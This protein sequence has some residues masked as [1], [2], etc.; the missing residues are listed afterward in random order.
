MN[1]P[2]TRLYPEPHATRN[3][4]GRYLDD[5]LAPEDHDGPFVY[6]NFVTSLDGRIAI[7]EGAD[8]GQAVPRGIANARD[9]RLFQE[10]AG[11]ADILVTSGRYLRDLRAGT[12]QDVLPVSTKAAFADIHDW[13]HHHGMSPQP[14]VLVLSA[15]LDFDPPH[16]LIEQDRRVIILTTPDACPDRRAHHEAAGADV[17]LCRS[18]AGA[19]TG[20]DAYAALARRGYRRVYSVTGPD[21]LGTLASAGV[22]HALFLTTVHCLL[23]GRDY[24]NFT[25]GNPLDPSLDLALTSMYLDASG[26][27]GVSQT[28]CRY[29]CRRGE[30]PYP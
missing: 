2:L 16:R 19:V 20:G 23:S 14:D 9:W 30:R 21:V 6:T 4:T 10:L 29:D 13:R 18:S 28:F 15:S 11:H 12:A 24:T 27:D 5:P 7:A 3:H 26:P 22:L 25:R 8:A 17:V 1:A